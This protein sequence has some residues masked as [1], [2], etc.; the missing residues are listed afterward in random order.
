MSS[1]QTPQNSI[2]SAFR[3]GSALLLPAVH[4]VHVLPRAHALGT[5]ATIRPWGVYAGVGVHRL[6]GRHTRFQAPKRRRHT[7]HTRSHTQ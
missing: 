7:R 6:G 3:F 2:L 5:P 1:R 4:R